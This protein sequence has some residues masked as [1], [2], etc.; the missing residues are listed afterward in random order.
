[1]P[2]T[3]SLP[4][5]F[6]YC[7]GTRYG[8]YGD[9]GGVGANEEDPIDD[10]PEPNEEGDEADK[11]KDPMAAEEKITTRFLTKYE[12]GT[13]QPVYLCVLFSSLALPILTYR[14]FPWSCVLCS[15]VVGHQSLATKP[16]CT[17]FGTCGG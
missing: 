2:L 12:R 4:V 15:K 9:D 17:P 5:F 6:L 13:L 16:R 11:D 7:V 1:M 8:D 10:A 3:L 14:C